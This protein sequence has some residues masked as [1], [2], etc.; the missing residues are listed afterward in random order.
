MPRKKIPSTGADS[1]L[2][3]IAPQYYDRSAAM[4][5]PVADF[6]LTPAWPVDARDDS[7]ETIRFDRREERDIVSCPA[8]VSLTEMHDRAVPMGE[9]A[10]LM[11]T[12]ADGGVISSSFC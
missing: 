12:D 2:F 8:P 10:A 1:P 7:V 5:M 11:T 6:M 3:D 9:R 4:R